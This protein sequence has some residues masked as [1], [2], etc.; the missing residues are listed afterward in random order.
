MK[1]L[2]AV[3]NEELSHTARFERP[4]LE[5]FGNPRAILTGLYGAFAPFGVSLADIRAEGLNPADQVITV[6][7]K[8]QGVHRFRFDRVETAFF[9]FSEDAFEKVP[10]ILDASL[11]WIRDALAGASIKSHQFVHTTHSKLVDGTVADVLRRIGPSAPNSGGTDI[12]SGAVFHWEVPQDGWATQLVVDRSVVVP[13]GLFLMFT[14]NV[15]VDKINFVDL[16]VR[17]REYLFG[18]LSDLGLGFEGF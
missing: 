8:Y 13:N 18:V 10:L 7:I 4:L 2:L 14:L 11:R 17:G 9:Q 15:P 5:L 3:Q 16:S 12:G 1:S 6:N